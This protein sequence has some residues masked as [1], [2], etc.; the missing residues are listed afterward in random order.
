M[1]SGTHFSSLNRRL[2]AFVF[3][4]ENSLPFLIRNSFPAQSATAYDSL[5][6]VFC[7]KPIDVEVDWSMVA[8]ASP[9]YVTVY[10]FSHC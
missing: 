7:Y 8:K 10:F 6:G 2:F 5:L 9:C 1:I 4:V 3:S